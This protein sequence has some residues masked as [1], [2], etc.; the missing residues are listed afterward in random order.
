[1]DA[2]TFEPKNQ[3]PLSVHVNL[4][5]GVFHS[6]GAAISYDSNQ[7]WYYY[8]RQSTTEVLVFHQYSKVSSNIKIHDKIRKK[9]FNFRANGLPILTLHS[10]TEIAQRELK[11]T[12]GFLQNQGW[13]YSSNN[14][15]NQ[16]GEVWST[17]QSN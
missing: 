5:V 9:K 3:I 10:S 2:R 1:M 11:R 15:A 12:R 17:L 13:R 14:Q 8:S 4:L 6:L 7:R 16:S